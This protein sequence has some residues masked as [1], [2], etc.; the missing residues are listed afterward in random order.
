MGVKEIANKQILKMEK[1]IA[2]INEGED[3]LIS[4]N[5]PTLNNLNELMNDVSIGVPTQ[6]TEGIFPNEPR[7]RW[8]TVQLEGDLGITDIQAEVRKIVE[9][10]VEKRIEELKNELRK[11]LYNKGDYHE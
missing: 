3:L 11:M 8:Y 2:Q 5:A 1:I 6:F 4:L 10:S 7:G 9:K